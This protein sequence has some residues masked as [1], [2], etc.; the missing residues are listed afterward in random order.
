MTR[1]DLLQSAFSAAWPVIAFAR[2]SRNLALTLAQFLNRTRFE[3]LPPKAIEHAKMIIASTLASA[4]PGSR[5]DSA[6]IVREL[7]K[8]GGG[9]PEATVWFDGA[10]L[11][12]NEAARVNAMLSDAAASDDSDL[13]NVAHTGT[14]LTSAG[15]A[16]GERTGATGQDL[17]GAIVT[18]YEAAGRIG[19]ALSGDRQGFHASVIVAFGGVVA[20]AR[21]LKL[22][23][24]QLAHAIGLTA[25]TMGGLA[26]GTNSWARE[27]HAGNAALCAV[28]A[29]MAAGRGYTV[30]EDMLEA[31]RGFLSVFGG[32]KVDTEKLTRD[33]G[34]D[35]DIVTHMAIKLV[36]GAHAFH[37]AVEAAVNAAR[38]SGVPPADVTRILVSGP[39]IRSIGP[40]RPPK[41]LIEAIH[42]LHYFL[43]SAVADKDFSWIHATP[44]KIHNP[45][46]TRLIGLIQSDPSPPPVHYDWGWGGTVTI[47]TRSGARYTS[48][49]DAPKA[50]GPRGIEW[51]D[52]DVKYRALMPDSGLPVKRIEEILNMIHAFDRVKNVS[53][54]TRLLRARP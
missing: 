25:T 37:P 53:E 35:W 21:L 15:L 52:V 20:A 51:N 54:L 5:I 34:K 36:P 18:G 39:Q 29:A 7:A 48:T 45:A 12:L 43:A 14:T 4:A 49:V 26:I 46:V 38:Q 31:P 30:N 40:G 27:Y 17:L 10:K 22:T 44:E 24:E 19:E 41:D 33:F 16:V 50:S 3:N 32:G 47:V 23:D 13:R 1:R 6:R 2:E 9:K 8:E 11:P 28:N 42:S